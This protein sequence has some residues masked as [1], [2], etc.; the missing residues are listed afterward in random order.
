MTSPHDGGS[1]D[2]SSYGETLSHSHR[3]HSDDDEQEEEEEGSM[4]MMDDDDDEASIRS[5]HAQD[6]HE[7]YPDASLPLSDNDDHNDDD[8]DNCH[9]SASSSS[10]EEEEEDDEFMGFPPGY[11]TNLHEKPDPM[12]RRT[13][14]SSSSLTSA[15]PTILLPTYFFCPLTQSIMSDPVVTR[16]GYTFERRAILRYLILSASNPFTGQP[17]CHEE[18]REDALVRNKIEKARREAWMRYVVEV[19]GVDWQ[20][21][22]REE[23]MEGG[24]VIRDDED[25]YDDEDEISSEEEEEEEGMLDTTTSTPGLEGCSTN[26]EE[27][28]VHSLVIDASSSS[29]S[30]E[31]EREERKTPQNAP[32]SY[33]HMRVNQNQNLIQSN[34]QG[35]LPVNNNSNSN[36][37]KNHRRSDASHASSTVI[38][39]PNNIHGWNTPLGVHKIICQPPG[40]V[41]TT[42]VHRR[43]AVVQRKVLQKKLVSRGKTREKATRNA[44]VQD[45]PHDILQTQSS[46][47]V[48]RN[49]LLSPKHKKIT[50]DNSKQNYQTSLTVS[51]QNLLLPPGSYVEITE[52]IV[53]GGRVRG[54]ICWEEEMAVELEEELLSL[55]RRWEE[56]EETDTA[57]R[58]SAVLG[59]DHGRGDVAIVEQKK[60]SKMFFRRRNGHPRGGGGERRG[61]NPFSSE[62]FTES[63]HHDM[64]R[65]PSPSPPP[66]TTVKYTGWISLQWAGLSNNREREEA[67]RRQRSGEGMGADEDDGPWSEPLP[68]GV[69]RIQGN[70]SGGGVRTRSALGQLPL[71]DAPD[72]DRNITHVLV[73]SQCVEVVETQ[74]VVM[75]RKITK[76]D[77]LSTNRHLFGMN[78]ADGVRGVRTVRAR[79]MVPVLIPPMV[80]QDVDGRRCVNA[81]AQKKFKSGWITL[82]TDDEYQPPSQHNITTSNALP[83]SLGAYIVVSSS[84]CTV[85]EGD[86]CDSKIKAILPCRSCIE[87]VTTRIEFEENESLL[88]CHC[89][90]ERMHSVVAVRALLASGGH[91]TLFVFPISTSG[92]FDNLCHCGTLVQRTI[93][94]PVPLG[95]YKIIH[96]GGV[97]LTARIGKDSSIVTML[98]EDAVVEVIQTGVEDG[99]VRGRVRVEEEDGVTFGWMNLFEFPDRRWVEYVFEQ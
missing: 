36:V 82:C 89:G 19:R 63:P 4:T 55:V 42:T 98:E 83:L 37:N 14:S 99:C 44:S 33:N 58:S 95:M 30:S 69:Y 39:E 75:K 35:V 92:T 13:S 10:S 25:D 70:G 51:S 79:C 56:E 34:F 5:D 57:R 80:P 86:R 28:E 24:G 52:T 21:I 94:E 31:E 62:L 3:H 64:V 46:S 2:G 60:K 38:T 45:I 15:Q 23:G 16:D 32:S 8:D 48:S 27:D 76:K 1:P 81:R 17:L 54:N 73:D 47:I 18:L 74:V 6:Y 26:D 9:S 96:P 29:S 11:I 22:V 41:V 65:R 66:I 87:V 71:S 91:V 68:L 43:S 40:L 49:N 67:A 90:S 77:R 78:A 59:K 93:A 12:P 97:S 84:G 61:K 20:R 88:T 7:H 72:S 50:K 85:T 53:H